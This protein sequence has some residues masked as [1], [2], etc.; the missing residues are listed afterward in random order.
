MTET[1]SV[2][3]AA[4]LEDVWSVLAD[5]ERW[6]TWTR[7]VTAV[8]AMSGGTPGPGADYEL[9]QPRLP[10]A[11]WEIAVW[12]PPSQFDW[13][14]RAPGVLTEASHVLVANGDG[15]TLT[16]SITRQGLLAPLVDRL[17]G[18][19]TREYLATEAASLKARCE[20]TPTA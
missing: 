19:I 3:I 10:K 1:T 15:T 11:T 7:T 18:R 4:R 6:P 5:V 20:G 13:V 8:R 12:D 14:S 9:E 2:E 17:Y 16:L